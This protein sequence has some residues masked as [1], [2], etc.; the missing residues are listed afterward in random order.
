MRFREWLCV[1]I[2][3]IGD[4]V[5]PWEPTP[6]K[7][8]NWNAPRMLDPWHVDLTYQRGRFKDPEAPE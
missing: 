8:D 4:W 6:T 3:R 2:Y 7:T 5:D 1:V